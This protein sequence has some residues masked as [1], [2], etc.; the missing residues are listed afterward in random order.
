[1]RDGAWKLYALASFYIRAIERR[2]PGETPKRCRNCSAF[3]V[4]WL[5]SQKPLCEGLLAAEQKEPVLCAA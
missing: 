2:F 1:M 4:E 5:K 3:A